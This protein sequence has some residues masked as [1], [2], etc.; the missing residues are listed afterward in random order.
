MP[1]RILDTG[2]PGNVVCTPA[3]PA[4]N[5]APPP[6]GG[7]GGSGGGGGGAP[8]PTGK[9]GE[10]HPVQP[11]PTH[12]PPLNIP[13]SYHPGRVSPAL[14]AHPTAALDHVMHQGGGI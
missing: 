13:G 12:A 2:D 7:G 6:G 9:P 10:K 5:P 14:R 3:P 4:T 8:P 1:V 11:K